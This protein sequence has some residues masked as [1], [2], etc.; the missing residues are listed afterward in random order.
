M[1]GPWASCDGC[2]PFACARRGPDNSKREVRAKL[3]RTRGENVVLHALSL[4]GA[5][6]RRYILN[7][8]RSICWRSEQDKNNP[9]DQL[10]SERVEH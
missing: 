6:K 3:N 2:L 9:L 1:R 4:P 8:T 7:T 5:T 10:R